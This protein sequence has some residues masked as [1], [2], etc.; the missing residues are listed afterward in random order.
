M[1]S[2]SMRAPA[3]VN[4]S[5]T[6]FRRAFAFAPALVEADLMRDTPA[7]QGGDHAP[8]FGAVH[9]WHRGRCRRS[10]FSS[11][12]LVIRARWTILPY[13]EKMAHRPGPRGRRAGYLGERLHFVLLW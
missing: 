12:S 5:P 10:S 6:G 11:N 8:A 7:V 3:L 2:P 13:R 1:F 9:G 4:R